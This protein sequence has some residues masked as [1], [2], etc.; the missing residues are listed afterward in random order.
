MD[1]LLWGRT[2]LVETSLQHGIRTLKAEGILEIMEDYHLTDNHHE[3]KT[4]PGIQDRDEWLV[5]FVKESGFL[6]VQAGFYHPLDGFEISLGS[7]P[8]KWET[9]KH[10][11]MIFLC[12]LHVS[13]MIVLNDHSLSSTV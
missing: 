12:V 10:D 1:T 5:L 8:M 9:V 7:V 2:Q 13:F 6:N 3:T 11:D 4:R